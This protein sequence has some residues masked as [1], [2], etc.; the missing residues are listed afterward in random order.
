[1]KTP[2]SSKSAFTLIEMLT[3]MAVI[4]VLA[5]LIVGIQAFAQKKAALTRADAEIHTMATACEAYKAEAGG[6]PR[7]VKGKNSDSDAL[8]P[9]VDGD[10]TNIKYQ[11][12]SIVLYKALSGD[13]NAD[14]KATG[15]LYSEFKPSQLQKNSSG[16]VKFIKDPFGNAY[17]YSTAGAAIEEQYRVELQKN[18]AAKRPTGTEIKGFNPTFDLWSTGGVISKTDGSA[19]GD[20]LNTE[21]KRW[22][23]NW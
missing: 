15:Q 14:G 3:V 9:R 5:S 1:M 10:P 8:D 7:D 12:A 11:K 4:A 21:R 6:Y 16:E 17:G 18:P 2:H 23:K 20:A 19:G 13:D 22:V